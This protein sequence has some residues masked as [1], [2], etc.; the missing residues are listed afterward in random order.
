MSTARDRVVAWYQSFA[1]NECKE[2][3][4]L[5]HGLSHFVASDHDLIEF[6][7]SM[8]EQQPNLFFASVQYLSGHEHFP[9]DG[10]A[11][12]GFV[13][14]RRQEVAALMTSRRTQTNEVGRCSSLVPAFPTGPVALIE[15]GASAGLCLLLDKYR[16]DYGERQIGDVMSS[17]RLRCTL[18]GK[19]R[20]PLALPEVVWRRGLDIAPVDLNNP[21]SVRWL[22]ACVWPD[23]TERRERLLAAMDVWMQHQPLVRVG[24]L[25][26]DL[27]QTIGDAPQDATLV[28]FHSAVLPYV[29]PEQRQAFVETLVEHSKNRDIVWISN[30]GR[31]LLPQFDSLGRPIERIRFQLART[32]IRAGQMSARLLAIAHAHGTEM[33]WLA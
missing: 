22:M 11:L 1:E 31:G 27:P 14:E 20:P 24:D 8:P 25:V 29:S 13:A 6:I 12:K 18:Q 17:V 10:T 3:S 23:H 26:K 7:S 2:Y 19:G 33:E 21:Q 16:Y 30:E 4:P 5:Y 32:V 9:R 15:V 28:I